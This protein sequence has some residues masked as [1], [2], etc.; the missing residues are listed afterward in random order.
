MTIEIKAPS[1][2]ESISEGT[3]VTWYKQPGEAVNRD[4]LLKANNIQVCIPTTPVQVFHMLRRQMI[5]PLRK[6]LIVM[7]AKSLLRHKHVVSDIQELAEGSFQSVLDEVDDL[8]VEAVR[9]VIMCSGKIYY[10][11]LNTRREQERDNLAI[12]RL[13]Q[14]YP[15]PEEELF[16]VLSQYPQLSE[17]TWVQE[18]P[19][20]QGAWYSTQHHM[21]RTISRHKNYITLSQ[22]SRD[23]SASPAAGNMAL[24]QE[25]QARVI[26]EAINL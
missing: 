15:F 17:L 13:E 23:A 26:D 5:R 19:L 7:T 9:R 6:P 24:H 10:D 18:E 3:V 4:E 22:V 1:F 12:I 14:L 11:L 16:N 21:R 20:N 2:P 25:Q 8:K